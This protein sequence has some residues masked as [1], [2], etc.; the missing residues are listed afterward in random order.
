[1]KTL[2]RTISYDSIQNDMERLLSDLGLDFEEVCLQGIIKNKLNSDDSFI[3]FLA[4]DILNDVMQKLSMKKDIDYNYSFLDDDFD[5][6]VI[7]ITLINAQK[8]YDVFSWSNTTMIV[9]EHSDAEIDGAYVL[10]EENLI[11]QSEED[12]MK[13]VSNKYSIEMCDLLVN[14]NL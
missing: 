11:A 10:L 2:I 9:G 6:A 12:A 13:V 5:F 7:G 14:R 1:M 4:E 3:D 8:K